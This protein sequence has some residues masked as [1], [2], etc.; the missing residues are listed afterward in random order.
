MK[1]P[2]CPKCKKEFKVPEDEL[3]EAHGCLYCGYKPEEKPNP[4]RL[5]T[6]YFGVETDDDQEAIDNVVTFLK[7]ANKYEAPDSKIDFWE[8]DNNVEEGDG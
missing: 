7:T 1:M 6:V 8:V 3:P 2:K 5:V 4:F